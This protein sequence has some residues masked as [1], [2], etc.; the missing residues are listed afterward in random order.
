MPRGV[1][2]W[3]GSGEGMCPLQKIFDILALKYSVLVRLESYLSVATR[4]GDQN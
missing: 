3:I 4:V 2:H 1:S